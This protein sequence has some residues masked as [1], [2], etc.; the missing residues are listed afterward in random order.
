MVDRGEEDSTGDAVSSDDGEPW[1]VGPLSEAQRVNCFNEL[2]RDAGV[3]YARNTFN[4]FEVS[5]AEQFRAVEQC[6]AYVSAIRERVQSGSG[7]L[8]IGKV[9]TGKDHLAFAIAGYAISR[10]FS[11]KWVRCLQWYTQ[12][13][14]GIKNDRSEAQAIYCALLAIAACAQ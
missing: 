14:D 13:R 5:A 4:N 7:L 10:G 8:L 12:M 9:G 2:A 11:A 1:V 6:R 3:R